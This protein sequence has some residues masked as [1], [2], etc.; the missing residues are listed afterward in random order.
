MKQLTKYQPKIPSPP[1]EDLEEAKRLVLQICEAFSANFQNNE[2]DLAHMITDKFT[3]RGSNIE[4][5]D[6]MGE[7]RL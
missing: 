7:K 2:T 3:L 1:A 4:M 6:T 5:R